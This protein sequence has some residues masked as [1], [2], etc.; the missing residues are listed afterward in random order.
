MI[1]MDSFE[2]FFGFVL[3]EFFPKDL[4]IL[5]LRMIRENYN[6]QSS[7]GF[8]HTV[9]KKIDGFYVCGENIYGQLGLGDNFDRKSMTKLNNPDIVEIFCGGHHTIAMTKNP[10]V[11]LVC[12]W[13]NEGQL[14]LGSY[15]NK[16]KFKKLDWLDNVISVSCGYNHSA[17]LTIYK[18]LF[19]WGSNSCGQLG[20]KHTDNRYK[21]TL[22]FEKFEH[23]VSVVCSKCYTLVLT[24]M[25]NCYAAGRNSCGQL[26]INGI[27]GMNKKKFT[28]INLSNIVSI[29]CGISFTSAITLDGDLFVWGNN[30]FNQIGFSNIG[31][32]FSPTKLLSNVYDVV[33]DDYHMFIVMKNGDKFRCGRDSH[34][35][36]HIETYRSLTSC[37]SDNKLPMKSTG[38]L[39]LQKFKF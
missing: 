37:T 7:H 22:S 36:T 34:L 39:M 16:N 12:G 17:V 4:I 3:R 9:I 31:S 13:N 10:K 23:I 2:L 18:Q 5:I 32:I 8:N 33:T 35:G 26:G 6:V 21:F 25:G 15:K 20:K 1:Y 24:N 14:G 30:K 29:K 28:K 38:S 11:L 27:I 19:I